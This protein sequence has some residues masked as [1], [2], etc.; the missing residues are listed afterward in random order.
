[1][2]TKSTNATLTS[3][4]RSIDI[5][6]L[7]TTKVN[8]EKPQNH[9]LQFVLPCSNKWTLSETSGDPQIFDFNSSCVICKK[10][11]SSLDSAVLDIPGI[12]TYFF[13]CQKC[14]AYVK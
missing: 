2:T 7:Y 13:M 4:Q 5:I 1:M 12:H 6:K 14:T 8:L 10:E 11:N 3:I 9:E